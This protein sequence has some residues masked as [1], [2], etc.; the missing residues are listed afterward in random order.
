MVLNSLVTLRVLLVVQYFRSH[1]LSLNFGCRFGSDL[2]CKT[3]CKGIRGFSRYHVLYI[4]PV[5]LHSIF[6]CFLISPNVKCSS[7][8]TSYL[9]KNNIF[10][11]FSPIAHFSTLPLPISC[12]Q[13][14]GFLC[15]KPLDPMF[16]LTLPLRS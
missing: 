13:L 1:N 10:K 2:F 12:E 9:V 6:E 5:S 15:I 11:H 3:L 4:I 7:M 14:H 8:F 16:F